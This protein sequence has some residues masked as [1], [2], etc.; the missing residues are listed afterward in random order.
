MNCAQQSYT[1][2]FKSLT[3]QALLAKKLN[4]RILK[5]HNSLSIKEGKDDLELFKHKHKE[6]LDANL[7]YLLYDIFSEELEHKL[8][9]LSPKVEQIEKLYLC[10]L[11]L[12][13]NY[14]MQFKN[15]E[16]LLES[17]HVEM[18]GLILSYE[19]FMS[20]SL[21]LFGNVMMCIFLVFIMI[22][23][24]CMFGILLGSH[25]KTEWNFVK[26]NHRNRLE[27][28]GRLS[29]SIIHE[30]RNPLA[31]IKGNCEIAKYKDES[32]NL[33]MINLIS[34]NC[35]RITK[36][37]GL[38]G[39]YNKSQGTDIKRF[40]VMDLIDQVKELAKLR[41]MSS[42]VVLKVHN[43]LDG[44]HFI[45]VDEIQFEQVLINLINNS[46][47]AIGATNA[48]WI[49]IEIRSVDNKVM[50]R[51]IDSGLGIDKKIVK[52]LFEPFYSTKLDQG[53][54]GLGLSISQSI[55]FSYGATLNYQLINGHTCFEIRIPKA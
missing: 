20:S 44:D 4:L 53:G 2:Y 25:R 34:R 27:H 16:L 38:V 49:E 46:I 22:L 17:Y 24:Y 8:K 21:K 50:I 42:S 19:Q 9:L 36:M 43:K 54:T 33:D 28:L 6:L 39:K 18:D 14:Q 30:I 40:N 41:I 48:A 3:S 45:N 1:K 37:I 32:I 35:D 29:S 15:L 13:P 12:C 7:S 52:R 26:R 51:I 47:E 11:Q 55:L 23:F 5:T 31:I 10:I